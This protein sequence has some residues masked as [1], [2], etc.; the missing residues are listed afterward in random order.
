MTKTSLEVTNEKLESE[1]EETKLRLRTALS[2]AVAVG[3]DG[4][5][6][7]ATVVTR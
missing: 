4:K 6:S 7:K 1:L 5:T 3:S 2:K